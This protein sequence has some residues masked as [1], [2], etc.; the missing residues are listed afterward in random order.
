M[1]RQPISSLT[2][3]SDPLPHF[4]RHITVKNVPSA[5][6][7]KTVL[8]CI[9]MIISMQICYQKPIGYTI[10]SKANMFSGLGPYGTSITNSPHG[11][12][13]EIINRFCCCCCCCCFLFFVFK[14]LIN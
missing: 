7:N 14:L 1:W 10:L 6:L 11:R 3:L 5:S 12:G 13:G 2:I 9:I 8:P 4:R